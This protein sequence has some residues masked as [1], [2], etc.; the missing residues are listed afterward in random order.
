[1]KNNNLLFWLISLVVLALLA[2]G[3]ISLATNNQGEETTLF[4]ETQIQANDHVQGSESAQNILIEYSDFQCP[5]CGAYYPMLKTLSEELADQVK[6]IYRHFPLESLHPNAKI[7]A[8][9]SEAA[10]QQG[11]FWE[12]YDKLFENQTDWSNEQNPI[13]KFTQYAAEIGLDP[14]QFKND[15]DSEP[16]KDKVKQDQG[17]ANSLRL[18]STPT[19]FLNGE[20]IRFN[21]YNQLKNAI[22][23][24]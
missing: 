4:D 9:A 7:A 19:F 13:E 11:K 20:K 21:S 14:E 17:F 10:G 6:L 5:A 1:M 18:N 15:L 16:V 24:N 3:M 8:L 2:W 22:K 12:M 23:Q